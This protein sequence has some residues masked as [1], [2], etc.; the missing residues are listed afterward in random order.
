MKH[1][2]LNRVAWVLYWGYW[3]LTILAAIPLTSWLGV[4][5]YLG[6]VIVAFMKMSDATQTIYES[7]FRN[8]VLVAIVGIIGSLLAVASF[9]VNIIVALVL[10]FA[11]LVWSA[12]RIVKGMLR[13]NSERAYDA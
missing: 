3:V 8:Y 7:H 4:L 12:Y 6:L 10:I 1:Q 11:V 9:F 2:E 5:G 13:L